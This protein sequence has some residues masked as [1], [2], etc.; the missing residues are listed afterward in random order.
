MSIHT[1]LA[2]AHPAVTAGVGAALGCGPGARFHPSARAH[3]ASTLLELLEKR[4]CHLLITECCLPYTRYPGALHMIGEIRRRWPELPIMVMTM[5]PGVG[6]LRALLALGVL[7]LYDK[8]EGLAELPQAALQVSRGKP[9]RC[10]RFQ[11]LLRDH[12]PRMLPSTLS[13]AEAQVVAMYGRGFNRA[14]VAHRLG[15]TEK[16]VKRWV[17]EAMDKI[18]LPHEPAFIDFAVG[19]NVPGSGGQERHH[20]NCW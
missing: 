4:P 11:Q 10:S 3:D 14:Q 6:T 20:S 17:R 7:G 9:Y 12:A 1:L 16:T 15:C 2:D 19:I 13:A 18:G 5:A 8:S